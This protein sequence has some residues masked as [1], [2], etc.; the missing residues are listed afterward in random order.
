MFFA[1]YD[2]YAPPW[3][4]GMSDG[5]I[6]TSSCWNRHISGPVS[7]Q[8]GGGTT[9]FRELW[10]VHRSCSPALSCERHAATWQGERKQISTDKQTQCSTYWMDK[11]GRWQK[12]GGTGTSCI[13][14]AEVDI[15]QEL[16]AART[17]QQGFRKLEA[18]LL[19]ASGGVGCGRDLLR[20]SPCPLRQRHSLLI[21]S[22][23]TWNCSKRSTESAA[24]LDRRSL[25][26]ST[27][28]A[29]V[30]KDG[31]DEDTKHESMAPTWMQV[32]I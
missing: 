27:V 6:L 9:S 22:N 12:Y 31:W 2:L 1:L 5:H 7:P 18:T 11:G 3:S 25:L 32:S 10:A 19:S 21:A 14:P 17:W 13:S 23:H 24:Q 26:K 29:S 16:W 20:A 30:S 4:F 28:V 8:F 15:L